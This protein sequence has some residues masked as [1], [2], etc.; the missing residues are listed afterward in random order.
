MLRLLVESDFMLGGQRCYHP[1]SQELSQS[2][3]VEKFVWQSCCRTGAE[4]HLGWHAAFSCG[5][6][7]TP[8]A[9]LNPIFVSGTVI[10]PPASWCF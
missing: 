5:S 3:A 8:A 7:T 4:M 1:G 9:T 2:H 6:E 10:R